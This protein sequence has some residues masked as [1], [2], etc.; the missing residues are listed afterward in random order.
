MI[1]QLSLESPGQNSLKVFVKYEASRG[2]KL[3]ENLGSEV[4]SDA[5]KSDKGTVG[6]AESVP[7]GIQVVDRSVVVLPF[8]KEPPFLSSQHF[9]PSLRVEA[10]YPLIAIELARATEIESPSSY[11]H[12]GLQEC[13]RVSCNDV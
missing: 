3:K 5:G 12:I 7:G 4:V 6:G 10:R 8:H 2:G 1:T 13:S 9:Q 11:T